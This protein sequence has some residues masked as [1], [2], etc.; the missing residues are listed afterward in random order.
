MRIVARDI[1]YANGIAS[2]PALDEIYVVSALKAELK[3]FNRKEGNGLRLMDSVA[4]GFL[5]D[6]VFVEPTTGIQ[7]S[8]FSSYLR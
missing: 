1:A 6:N 7:V 4:L 8:T 3:M 2:N 5:G